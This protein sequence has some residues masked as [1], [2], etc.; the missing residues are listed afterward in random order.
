MDNSYTL[1]IKLLI[2]Y[3]LNINDERKKT[4]YYFENYNIKC[5]VTLTFPTCDK[6]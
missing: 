1:L 3:Y 4:I 2:T 5:D 6:T